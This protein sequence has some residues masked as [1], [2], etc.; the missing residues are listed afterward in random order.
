MTLVLLAR[1]PTDSVTS[2][3]L[4]AAQ[5]A[6]HRVRILT[7]DPQSHRDRYRSI[8]PSLDCPE[9][10]VEGCEVLDARAVL[11][12]I[13]TRPDVVFSNS[14][15]LQTQTALA[16][17]YFELPGKDWRSAVRA[18]DKGLMRT[19]LHQAGL[20]DT[21]FVRLRPGDP[22]ELPAEVGYP[23][24]LKPAEGVASEDVVLVRD[25]ADLERRIAGIRQHRDGDLLVEGFIQGPLHTL[26]TLGDGRSL[27]IWGGYRT[28]VST[29]PYFVEER[30]TWAP[31]LPA[32]VLTEVL[33]QL[34]ALGVG[35][36]P[37]HTEFIVTADGPR[38]VEVNDRLIGDHCDFAM[39][40]LLAEPVFD[41]ALRVYLGEPAPPAPASRAGSPPVHGLVQWV[42]ATRAGVLTSGPSALRRTVSSGGDAELSY[43]PMRAF[44]STVAV[45][46]T[47]RD[48]LGS[49]QVIGSDEAALEAAA[50]Q[51]LSAEHWVIE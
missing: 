28:T 29:E 20:D 30:L 45:T 25:Q 33:A 8:C 3:L 13:G 1:N 11:A 34:E 27:R 17:D 5:R 10:E 19:A 49:I 36:G 21:P 26:E 39:A 14:D 47:N 15:H 51:F 4:P 40:D 6:G 37:V 44:G 48:Y 31:D 35:F 22:S 23:S 16:A 2:G 43:R 42:L 38:I 32:E 7:D 50:A 9:P 18:R 12:A 46:G 24:V 41:D